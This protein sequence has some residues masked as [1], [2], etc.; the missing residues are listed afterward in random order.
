VFFSDETWFILSRN[1]IAKIRDNAV[2]KVTMCFLNDPESGVRCV[3]SVLRLIGQK[4]C[5]V[6]LT[7]MSSLFQTILQELMEDDVVKST[8]FARN[9]RRFLKRNF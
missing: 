6:I 8:F 3:L 5:E 1:I 7:I 9:G 2:T 4:F